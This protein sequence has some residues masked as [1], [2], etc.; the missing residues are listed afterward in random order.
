[1]VMLAQLINM[2]IL[3]TMSVILFKMVPYVK[4]Y[5]I[6]KGNLCIPPGPTKSFNEIL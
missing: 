6:Q 4:F 5:T 1:M 2:F 3:Q